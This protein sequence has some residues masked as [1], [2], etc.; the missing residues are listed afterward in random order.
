MKPTNKG[1][2]QKLEKKKSA[3]RLPSIS[4]GTHYTSDIIQNHTRDTRFSSKNKISLKDIKRSSWAKI[5]RIYK[6]YDSENSFCSILNSNKD[7]GLQDMI[8]KYSGVTEE[9]LGEAD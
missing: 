8:H 7:K 5:E 9:M 2:Q 3:T 1:K 6:E 4:K